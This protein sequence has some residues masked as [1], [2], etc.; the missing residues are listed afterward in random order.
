MECVT[1]RTL[2][3]WRLAVRGHVTCGS[4]IVPCPWFSEIADAGAA[5]PTIDLGVHLTM[6]SERFP[7]RWRPIS[8][9]SRA[10]GLIDSDGYVWRDV[11][12][13]RTNVVPE[14][15]EIE[16]RAQIDCVG[17]GSS[18]NAYRRAYGRSD[19]SRANRHSRPFST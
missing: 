7:Y 8:T 9:L 4:A 13:M 19:G 5:D 6:T 17:S 1:G 12:L 15:A 10:S 14:V 18:A 11:A 3:S 2:P 16:L